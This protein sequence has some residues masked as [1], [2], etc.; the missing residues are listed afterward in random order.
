MG[1]KPNHAQIK[2]ENGK[3]MI[4]P[5]DVNIFFCLKKIKNFPK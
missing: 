2:N 1:I 5:A 4:E 3:I